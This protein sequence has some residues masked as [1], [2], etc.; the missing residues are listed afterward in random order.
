[1]CAEH[2]NVLTH[3]NK[4]VVPLYCLQGDDDLW[5]NLF[6]KT[7]NIPDRETSPLTRKW[8]D[9]QSRFSPGQQKTSVAMQLRSVRE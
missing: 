6:P 9:S 5:Q 7:L 4:L 8:N 1:M 2:N 3:M